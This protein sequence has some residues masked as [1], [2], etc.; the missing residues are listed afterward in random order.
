[1][2]NRVSFPNTTYSIYQNDYYTTKKPNPTSCMSKEMCK[3]YDKCI[4]LSDPKPLHNDKMRHT[5]DQICS[6]YCSQGN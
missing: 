6:K 4:K 3:C 5:K 1:M 2:S